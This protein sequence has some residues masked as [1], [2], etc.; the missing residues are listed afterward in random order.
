MQSSYYNFLLRAAALREKVTRTG[1][2]VL[3]PLRETAF[4]RGDSFTPSRKVGLDFL[5]GLLAEMFGI[6]SWP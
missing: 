2:C 5:H 3:A 6:H 4:F 1:H